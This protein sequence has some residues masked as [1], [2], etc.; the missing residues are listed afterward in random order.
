MFVGLF[1]RAVIYIK[2]V[3][4][5]GLFALMSDSRLFMALSQS[6]I[7]YITLPFIGLLLTLLAIMNGY[8]LAKASNKNFDKWFEFTTSAVCAVLSSISLYGAALSAIYG[9]TF[10]AGIWFFV[11]SI[12]L[13][14]THQMVMLG[15]NIYRA[16]ESLP[17]SAQRMHYIQ[18]A[19]NK[20][21]ALG[22]LTAVT[23]S[24]VF[25]MLLPIAPAIGTAF[26]LTAVAITLANILWQII[27]HNW[28]LFIKGQLCLGKP[29]PIQMDQ[30]HHNIAPDP[31][32]QKD[33]KH[34]RIFTHCDY[35]AEV[36]G[37]DLKKAE[38]YL[39]QLITRKIA[40][41][42]NDSVPATDKNNQKAE[43]LTKILSALTR[44]TEISSKTELLKQYPLAFQS[45]WAEKGEV[46][47]LFEAASVLSTKY[48]EGVRTNSFPA[49]D[50]ES[51]R[52]SV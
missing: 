5:V 24:I 21:F 44:H 39:Q 19:I 34:H 33:I 48:K 11:S 4:D 43:V 28:K 35:S 40:V 29:E 47:Q 7:M 36:K 42:Q 23:G 25:V 50:F 2:E 6:P 8:D 17:G 30:S 9:F 32:V 37:M 31:S 45:F 22:L 41:L 13:A 15:L 52:C 51:Q 14:S 49:D 12:A 38:G 18:A 1:R 26:A 16:H 3:Q 10:T 46:E 27:P 20:L